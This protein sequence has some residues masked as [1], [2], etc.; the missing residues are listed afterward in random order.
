MSC[1]TSGGTTTLCSVG[2]GLTA[3]DPE[4]L[5]PPTCTRGMAVSAVCLFYDCVSVS[6]VSSSAFLFGVCACVTTVA[7][8]ELVAVPPEPVSSRTRALSK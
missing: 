3:A 1:G 4:P 6:T 7:D 5:D 8:P 2:M